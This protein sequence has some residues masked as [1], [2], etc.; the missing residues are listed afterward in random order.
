MY[1]QRVTDPRAQ[2]GPAAETYLSSKVHS[3]PTALSRLVEVAHPS[4]GTIV[5]VATG[6]GHAAFTFAPH[7]ERVIAT[8]ITPNMLRVTR[9]AALD[10]G[11]DNLSC[12]FALAEQLPFQ[13]GRLDGIVCRLGAHHFRDLRMFLAGAHASLKSGAWFLLAD[14]IGS[15]DH[16]TDEQIDRFERLRDPSHMRDHSR[17]VWVSM[18]NAAGLHVVHDEISA[19]EIDATDWMERMNVPALDR[20]RLTEMIESST[21]QFREYLKPFYKEGRLIFHLDEILLLARS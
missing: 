14:T 11:L 17:S 7:V 1:T 10:R 13:S 3:N 8:D 4:G 9:K 20:E 2:F 12:C 21:G 18:A 19:K 15:E 16:V 6:A 5:D